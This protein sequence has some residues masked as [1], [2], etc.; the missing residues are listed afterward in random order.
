[1][2]IAIVVLLAI[3]VFALNKVR[4]GSSRPKLIADKVRRGDLIET[5]S[6][7]GSVNAQ[8]PGRS[9]HG[10]QLTGVIKRLFA[11]V[12]AKVKAGQLIAELDLPDLQANLGSSQAAFSQAQTHFVQ[13]VTGVG[14]V[15]TQTSTGLDAAQQEP[16]SV[17][18]LPQRLPVLQLER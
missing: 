1:M 7:T 8:E 6:A 14:Q 3:G 16:G 2:V 13:Q 18:G 12:G 15:I 5:V 9:P 11:D 17:H 10:S 4:A